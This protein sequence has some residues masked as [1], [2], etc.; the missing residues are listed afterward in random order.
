MPAMVTFQLRLPAFFKEEDGQTVAC[1]P[2]LDI[3]THGASRAHAERAL[4]EAT[5]LFIESCFER[6]VL[7][8]VLK[9]C[10]FEPAQ[11]PVGQSTQNDYLTVPFEL[12]AARNGASQAHSC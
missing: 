2:M 10:G 6:G 7:D 9:A 3:V 11:E 4:I 8:D 5:Q 1:F 12:L